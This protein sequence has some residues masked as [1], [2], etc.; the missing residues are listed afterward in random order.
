MHRFELALYV[1]E[2]EEFEPQFRASGPASAHSAEDRTVEGGVEQQ[3]QG[4]GGNSMI[5]TVQEVA[6]QPWQDGRR[7]D[8]QKYSGHELVQ[9]QKAQ[10]L[11]SL[12][13]QLQQTAVFLEKS[14]W[15]QMPGQAQATRVAVSSAHDGDNAVKLSARRRLFDANLLTGAEP[16]DMPGQTLLES[17]QQRSAAWDKEGVLQLKQ[18]HSSKAAELNS[19][20]AGGGSSTSAPAVIGGVV[21]RHDGAATAGAVCMCQNVYAYARMCPLHT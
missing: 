1:A 2:M 16:G 3:R 10:A 21:G 5:Q 14:E 19:V 7:A 9:L 12:Q 11:N 15:E 17:R 8:G 18:L 4:V 20:G 6:P 13:A